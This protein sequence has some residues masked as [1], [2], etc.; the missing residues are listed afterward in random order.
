MEEPRQISPGLSHFWL[1]RG[2]GNT[3]LP[4]IEPLIG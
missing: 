1:L 4:E 3:D 2:L